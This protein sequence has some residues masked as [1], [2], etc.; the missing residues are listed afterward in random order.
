MGCRHP[1]PDWPSY[2]RGQRRRGYAIAF[3][4]GGKAL[5]TATGGGTASVWDLA[6]RSRV[7]GPFTTG[8]AQTDA[9][10]FSPNGKTL[11]RQAATVWSACGTWPSTARSAHP[12]G[13]GN[14]I[15]SSVGSD[16]KTLATMDAH[17]SVRLLDVATSAQIGAPMK[18]GTS[19]EAAAF[20]PD[21]KTFANA[22]VKNSN[23]TSGVIQLW[24]L[25][26]HDPI[27]GPLPGGVGGMDAVA[28]TP[29]GKTLAIESNDGV[30]QL[31]DVTTH[32]RIGTRIRLPQIG[33]GS[34]QSGFDI[35]SALTARRSPLHPRITWSSCGMWPPTPG[36]VRSWPRMGPQPWRK[37]RSVLMAS[38]SP[39]GVLPAQSDCGASPPMPRWGRHCRPT[40][41]KYSRLPSAR[42]AG[43]LPP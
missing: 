27:G 35:G 7:G 40:M 19:T 26:T 10:A 30:V 37:W 4:P 5:A 22:I 24:S 43:L 13:F 14:A 20:S 21:G 33:P 38:S 3:S 2:H 42:T 41:A 15:C 18:V 1:R 28:F 17:G 8:P 29:N 6:T 11:P 25:P 16:G 34:G 12:S 9:V 36:S 31:W 23:N 39:P 32:A